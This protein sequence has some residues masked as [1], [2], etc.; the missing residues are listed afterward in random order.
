MYSPFGAVTNWSANGFLSV[1]TSIGWDGG[2][3]DA[4]SGLIKFDA[5]WYNP[6]TTVWIIADPSGFASGGTNFYES[7]NNNPATN[8]D[9]TGLGSQST[10]VTD[11]GNQ[12]LSLGAA[13]SSWNNYDSSWLGSQNTLAN[14]YFSGAV[15]FFT[16]NSP[17]SLGPT[18]PLS[19]TNTTFSPPAT[20]SLP[21]NVGWPQDQFDA[22]LNSLPQRNIVA[23]INE[24]WAIH[25]TGVASPAEYT[26]QGAGN[27]PLWADG[28]E[29]VAQPNGLVTGQLVE[30]KMLDVPESSPRLARAHRFSR[31][32]TTGEWPT[33]SGG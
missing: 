28:I 7:F 8:V 18:S 15:P 10:S 4:N 12:G 1:A 13:P 31:R 9:P 6:T 19:L 24:P 22:W 20:V 17:S 33:S 25:Q 5:R 30:A 27:G 2:L 32:C 3:T 29:P 26:V 21:S 16:M 14:T 23:G 11:Y